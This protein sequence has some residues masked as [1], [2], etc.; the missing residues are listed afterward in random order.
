[1]PAETL[2]ICEHCDAVHRRVEVAAGATATCATCGAT[3]YRR[4]WFGLDAM[5]A[6]TCAGLVVFVLANLYPL[7]TMSVQGVHAETALWQMIASAWDS[8][9]AVVA[10]IAGLT[11][12][13]FPLLQLM[14]YAYLLFPLATG[15]VPRGLVP[16][17]HLLRQLRPWSMVEV[18]LIGALVTLVKIGSLAEVTPRAGLWSFAALTCL[19]TALASFDSRELW[20]AAD[21]IRR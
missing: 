21:E 5:L 4:P 20:R 6:L 16:A 15:R 13:V 9:I 14:L 2:I 7:V 10:G 8:G 19:L 18:F 12:F 17:M 11:V 1:M 3:L